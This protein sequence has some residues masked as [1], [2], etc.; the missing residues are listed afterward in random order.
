VSITTSSELQTAIAAW[1]H[2]TG[3]TSYTGS[4]PDF[5]AL[6]EADMQVRCKLME[7]ETPSTVT[8]TSGTGTLPTGYV[9]I[10]SAYWVGSPNYPLVYITPEKYDDLRGNDSG[11]ADYYTISGSSIFTTPMGSGS[12]VITG[13]L[14]F[15]ALSNSNTTNSLLSNFPDAYLYGSLF[16]AALFR[17]D[18]EAAQKWLPLFEKAVGR[19]NQNN[20]ERKFAGVLAVRHQ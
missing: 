8:I 7:F 15:T 18:D 13:P 12:L 9:G 20:E 1:D 4:V 19:I 5:I 10:R 14:K 2:R 6:C 16:Q 17:A 3:D 11:D